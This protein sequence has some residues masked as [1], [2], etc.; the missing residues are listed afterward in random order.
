MQLII[1]AIRTTGIVKLIFKLIIDLYIFYIQFYYYYQLAI[2]SLTSL[3]CLVRGLLIF[4]T[5][6]IKP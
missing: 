5:Q 6:N 2:C 1:I 4:D 3:I